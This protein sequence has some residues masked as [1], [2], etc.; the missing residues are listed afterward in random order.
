[1]SV[2]SLGNIK[3]SCSVCGSTLKGQMVKT[4]YPQVI[5]V[6]RIEPC[7]VCVMRAG[8]AA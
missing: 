5:R 3:L 1:M 6:L 7:P 8:R 4:G 2:N